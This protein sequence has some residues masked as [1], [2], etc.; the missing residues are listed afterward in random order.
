MKGIAKRIAVM[1]FA[2]IM[3]VL[4][5][6]GNVVPAFAERSFQMSP[7]YE[8]VILNPGDSYQSSFK[9]TNLST[10][11]DFH[12]YIDVEPYYVSE[13]YEP[14]FTNEGDKNQIVNWITID[15]ETQRGTLK[16]LED[17]I[18]SFV[19]NV[20]ENAAA[21]GQYAAITAKSDLAAE[22]GEITGPAVGEITGIAYTFYAEITGA[23]IVSGE[24]LDVA[25]PSIQLG[26]KVMGVSVV[27]NTGNVHSFAKYRL[28]VKPAFSDEVVYDSDVY[29]VNDSDKSIVFP[30]RTYKEEE[31]W[32]D[33]P[34]IGIFNVTYTVDFQGMN[35]EVTSM[36]IVCPGWLIFLASIGLAILIVRITMVIKLQKVGKKMKEIEKK[37]KNSIDKPVML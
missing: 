23:S 36:V 7:M 27:K 8:N 9:L 10:E 33:T 17:K 31:Y 16:P 2:I 30:D 19:V 5:V 25:V 4:Y 32:N 14:I 12:Y 34:M 28:Q 29:A 6:I 26:G 37:S 15:S 3:G 22:G 35:S 20:P 1:G 18:I 21:G 11:D 13:D 24:I